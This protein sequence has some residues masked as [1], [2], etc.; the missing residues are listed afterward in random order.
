MHNEY[1][2]PDNAANFYVNICYGSCEIF[3]CIGQ[4]VQIPPD[5]FCDESSNTLGQTACQTK[6]DASLF[7][8][9]VQFP[10]KALYLPSQYCSNIEVSDS[11]LT[12]SPSRL[13]ITSSQNLDIIF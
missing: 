5:P 9:L 8:L 2:I 7:E 12:A 10:P 11:Y 3:N 6:K 13:S 1:K 4:S